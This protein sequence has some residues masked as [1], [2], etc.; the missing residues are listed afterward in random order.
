M[1]A[2]TLLVITARFDATLDAIA[3]GRAPRKDFIELARALDADV[4]DIDRVAGKLAWRALRRLIGLPLTLAWIAFSLRGRYD[5]IY[6]DGEHIGIPLAVLLRLSRR[7]PRHVMIGHLLT[8]PLK[9]TLFRWLRPQRGLDAVLVHAPLQQRLAHEH[10]SLSLSQLPLVPYGVDPSFWTPAAPRE[11]TAL[12]CSAGLEYRDYS[13]LLAAVRNL[14]VRTVIAAGSR[15][16]QHRF[17][18]EGDQLPANIEVTELDY[19]ELRGLYARASFVV[20]PLHPVDNQAGITTILEAMAM[21]KAVIVTATAGQHDVIRGRLCTAAGLAAAPMG[22]PA[23]F[24]ASGPLAEAETG[25]YVPPGD[26]TALR[27]AIQYLLDHP[28]EAVRMGRAGRR[29]VAE[30]MSL[31]QFVNRVAGMVQ[32]SARETL[33]ELRAGT[34]LV[35]EQF[36]SSAAGD[37]G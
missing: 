23:P 5:N 20:V 30:Q 24:G 37:G 11:D 6:C 26:P 21:S 15:W 28:D 25:L 12:I 16:S 36:R 10:L 19:P 9:R 29:V 27:L 35:L 1:A 18:A 33:S 8:T 32:G 13:T 4:L 2:R 7:R 31:D 34:P 14:P 3:A 17:I 22:G